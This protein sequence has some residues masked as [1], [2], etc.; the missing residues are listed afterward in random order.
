[1]QTGRPRRGYAV[2]V[3]EFDTI[4]TKGSVYVVKTEYVWKMVSADAQT[5]FLSRD[6]WIG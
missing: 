2:G 1:M 4:R 3:Q 6:C 5:F